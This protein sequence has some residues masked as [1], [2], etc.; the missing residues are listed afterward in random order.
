MVDLRTL[1]KWRRRDHELR[2]TGEISEW[3]GVGVFQAGVFM[4]PSKSSRKAA[5]LRAIVSD[6]MGWDHVSVSLEHRCPT[7]D[8]MEQT[9]RMFFEPHE[10]A[11]QLHPSLSDYKNVHPY[12]LHI[13]RPHHGT[14]PMPPSWFVA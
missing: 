7:W 10:T 4:Y 3:E 2:L 1:E 5:I 9:K 14:I 13:W 11:M 6:A 8:E 12:C